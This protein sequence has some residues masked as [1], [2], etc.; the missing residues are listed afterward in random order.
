MAF[1]KNKFSIGNLVDKVESVKSKIT[2]VTGSLKDTTSNLCSTTVETSK[3]WS[4]KAIDVGAQAT[5]SAKKFAGDTVDAI[6]NFDYSN[7]FEKASE[8]ATS[9]IDSVT[10]YFKRTLE[11][12]KTTLEVVQEIRSSLPTPVSTADQIFE[13]CRDEAL[14]RTIAAFMLGPILNNQDERSALKYDKLSVDWKE[15]RTDKDNQGIIGSK[16]EN[17]ARMKSEIKEEGIIVV[18]G[19]NRD[20]PLTKQK[21]NIDV[22]HVTSRKE[23]FSDVLLKIGLTNQE[24]G[25]VM[26]DPRNLVYADKKTNCQKS[27]RD[28]WEWIDKFKDDIQPHEDKVVITIRST[29][30][31]R[32]LDKR[33][34]EEAYE[35]SKEAV[36]EAK[37]NAGIEVASTVVKSGVG[38]ALQQI[39]GLIIVETIDIFMDEIKNFKLMTE[40]GLIKDLQYKKDRIY[41]RLN[42]RFE[43]RQIWARARDLGIESGVS[44]A[45][46]VI[47]QIIISLFV[48]MPAFVYA[49][50][51]ESTLSVVRSVRILCSNEEGKLDHLKVIMFGTASAIAGVYVQ[52]VITTAISGVPLL[53]KFHTQ[54]GNVLSGMIIMA[55]PLVAIYTFDQ[56]KQKL[57]FCLKK[58]SGTP[59]LSNSNE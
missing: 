33:D 56:N 48:K 37:I 16:H 10:N 24:L 13:Q 9:G 7:N 6:Q 53:N 2:D 1:L 8:F 30:E 58:E 41:T 32:V 17:Y 27:D 20:D 12:D 5:D 18:N 54:I 29:G 40:K 36:R 4:A 23:L 44:G 46:S 28:I 15:F 26:N 55:I 51:R 39:V 42:Q 34:L 49:I 38:V 11:V 57:M 22:E 52:R 35:R 47:P 45:L 31:K 43:E 59:V 25:E 50:I 14:R 3:E 19:Y 21:G